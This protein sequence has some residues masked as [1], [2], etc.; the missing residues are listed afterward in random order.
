MI[1]KL[2]RGEV[3][4]DKDKYMYVY[5]ADWEAFRR[6]RKMNNF[7]EEEIIIFGFAKVAT[8]YLKQ[9]AADVYY[10]GIASQSPYFKN[11]EEW[12]YIK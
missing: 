9:V 6:W 4:L 2:L 12:G 1:K 8:D 11:L 10:G 5:F 3:K 7:G